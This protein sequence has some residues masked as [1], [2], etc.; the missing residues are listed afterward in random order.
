M[1]YVEKGGEIIPKIVGVN[2]NARINDSKPVSFITHC[3]ACGSL[4]QRI[5]GEAAWVC[6]NKYHCPPQI[7]GRIE[8]FVGR[9]AMNIDGIGEE[10]AE[11]LYNS[12]L[13][14]DIADLYDLSADKL[15]LLDRFGLKSAQRIIKGID[16]SR[17]VPFE[18]VIY[19]LSIPYVGET[20]AKKLAFASTNIDNLMSMS[21]EQLSAIDEIGVKIAQSVIDFFNVQENRTIV[22]R[23]RNAGLQMQTA[24]DDTKVSDKL[25]GKTI[26]ISGVFNLHSRDEYKKMIEVN[27]GKNSGSISAKTSYLLAGENMGP[28][29]LE[30][31]QKLG[32][33]IIDEK[34]FLALLNQEPE[35][36]L[37]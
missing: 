31:A 13:V 26:V 9:H 29:K 7:T 37:Q 3:P 30:K 34:Q 14:K 6:P 21:L 24:A 2:L 25:A 5:E 35:N 23:L 16:E 8:H 4:L 12:G 1:L 27:G 22:E 28:A 10:V 11:Q 36:K 15:M 33:T 32:I 20:V 17:K 18:R 19:A